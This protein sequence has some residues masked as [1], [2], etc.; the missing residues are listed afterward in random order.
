LLWSLCFFRSPDILFQS[1]LLQ[2]F[3]RY[4]F[5]LSQWHLPFT[6]LLGLGFVL[7]DARVVVNAL[8]GPGLTL[9][10]QIN[11]SIAA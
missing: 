11:A 5:R 6:R 2:D 9:G 4:R 7:G 1:S 8:A 10:R 3:W